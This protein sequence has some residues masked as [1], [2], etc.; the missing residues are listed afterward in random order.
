MLT[1]ITDYTQFLLSAIPTFLGSEP[2]IYI[3]GVGLFGYV[4][5]L[6]IKLLKN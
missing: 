1:Q 3:I 6:V 4:F 5:S 2:I